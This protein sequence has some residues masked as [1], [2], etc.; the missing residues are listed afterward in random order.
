MMGLAVGGLGLLVLLVFSF[1]PYYRVAVDSTWGD[2]SE[3]SN[4]WDS[5]ASVLGIVLL[6]LGALVVAAASS[7]LLNSLGRNLALVRLGGA[8]VTS[9]ALVFFVVSAFYW[10]DYSKHIGSS[11]DDWGIKQTRHVGFYFIL[12][13]AIAAAGLSW[14]VWLKTKN[15][16]P[17]AP[18]GFGQAP[19]GYSQP[20]APGYAQQPPAPPAP[21]TYDQP[22]APPAPGTYDQPPAPPAPG[23][24]GQPPAPG[25]GSP[26]G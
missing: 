13:L 20:P 14:Y 22:P 25:Y 15:V 24:Y 19:Q 3:S 18:A 7:G 23:G 17:A 9:L 6:V 11:G 2:Y 4:A 26:Q 21:G 8:A 16:V 12:L 1:L 10:S 5:W